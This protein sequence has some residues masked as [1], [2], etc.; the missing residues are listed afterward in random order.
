MGKKTDR[1]NKSVL[2]ALVDE[3]LAGRAASAYGAA[4]FEVAVVGTMAAARDALSRPWDLIV[5]EASFADGDG[6][7]LIARAPDASVH[8]HGLPPAERLRWRSAGAAGFIA[9]DGP[10]PELSAA[11]PDMDDDL[12]LTGSSSAIVTLRRHLRRVAGAGGRVLIVGPTGSGKER[13]VQALHRMGPRR[14]AP[15]VVVNAAAVPEG[16]IDSELF[17][18]KAGAFTD[19]TQERVGRFVEADGGVLVLDQIEDLPLAQ[20]ARLLRVLETGE[21]T[22][23]GGSGQLV[24]VQVLATAHRPLEE[25][26]Q[27]GRF[28]ADLYHRLAVHELFVP[29]LAERGDDFP[30][31]VSE[32]APDLEAPPALVE[33]LRRTDWPGNV[34]QLDHF[35]ERLSLLAEPG[36]SLV[37][38]ATSELERR[39]GNGFVGTGWLRMPLAELVAR[40]VAA[41]LPDDAPLPEGLYQDVLAEVERGLFGWVLSRVGGKQ[42]PAARVLG[43]N[44]NTLRKKLKALGMLKP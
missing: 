3:A 10:W 6:M 34:R 28:R 27:A 1:G 21:V 12:G 13:V 19:A 16:L 2:I 44:R 22:P 23:I 4:R 29:A 35:L 15:M 33:L 24:D 31:L 11:M 42:L 32:L 18:H 17:G 38:L 30:A 7:E 37:S 43:I 14:G 9:A 8:V 39:S 20:Q 25:A 40:R 5:A 36:E 26:V 41:G